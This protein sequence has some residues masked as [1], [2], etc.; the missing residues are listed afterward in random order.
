MKE[1]SPRMRRLDGI[2]K[3]T[4]TI[5]Y[6]TDFFLPDMAHAKIL[7]SPH[8]HARI[9]A[10][11]SSKAE[12]VPGV[13]AV[14]TGAHIATLPDPYY[15]VGIRDQPLLAIGKVRYVGDM[16]AAIVAM[17]EPT[18]YRALELIEVAYE[19]LPAVMTMD[20]ALSPGAPLLF[21][22]P[23]R[24]GPLPVGEGAQSLKEPR[25]NVLYEFRYA[26]GEIDQAFASAS[27]LFTDTFVTSRI[28]HLHLEPY[29]NVARVTG[30]RIELWSCNQDPFILRADIARIF[31]R[32]LNDVRIHT[33]PVGGGFGGKSYCKMEP[34]VAFLAEYVQRPVRLCLTMDEA[35][36]TLSKHACVLTLTT[37]VSAN[38]QLLAR[39]STV[40]LDGGAY[41]DASV[42][43]AIKA[44]YRMAGCYRWNALETTAFAVRTNTVPAGSFRGFGGTQ[45]SFASESQIDMIARRLGLDPIEFRRLNLL[46]PGEPYAPGDSVI[47]SDF[48]E[49]LGKLH[50]LLSD[51]GPKQPGRGRGVAIG[52]KDGGGTGNQA[53]AIVKVTHA[54]DVIVHAA[55]VEVGQGASTAL[56]AIAADVLNCDLDRVRYGDID[57]DHTP[58]DTGTHVSFATTV[59]GLAVQRAAEEARE[60]ILTF[61]AG[62]I[63]CEPSELRLQGWAVQHHNEVIGLA[64]LMNTYFGPVG[65]EFVGRGQL[66]IP[67]EATAPLA[68]K[69]YFWMPCWSGAEV[70]VDRDTGQ[71]DVLHLVIGVDAGRMVNPAACRGQAEGAALQAFGQALFEEFVYAGDAP[72]NA[73][74]LNYRA[75]LTT[76]LPLRFESFVEG[77]GLGPGPGGIKGIGESGMLGLAA[78]IANAVEDA[79]GVRITDLPITP[80][81]VKRALDASQRAA[82]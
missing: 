52:L 55:A 43:T 57:T 7:R 22:A 8:A 46:A 15:G 54:G 14:V 40:M 10:I 82:E 28:N 32:P 73:M 12:A 44:G 76:D 25:P 80:E 53:N 26:R 21:E 60:Q 61:A 30:G 68:S 24:G 36:L 47:D 13:L 50:A 31:D 1:M 58:L 41:S 49:G 65:T 4:G 3:V 66:K 33:P 29:I 42:S 56:A 16:V 77:Q 11:D 23:S 19:E 6:A 38:G 70:A 69:N 51:K 9:R 37:G 2:D 5:R 71:V 59:S 78:A 20:T 45:A 75:P 17:D 34:L 79:V 62:R 35:L 39:R 74:P 18:A 27:H 81:K 63:G 64:P 67:Y 48:A 72:A